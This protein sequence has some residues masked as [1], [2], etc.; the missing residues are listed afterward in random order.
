MNFRQIN[1]INDSISTTFGLLI[2]CILVWLIR[3]TR[4]DEMKKYNG[5]LLQIC[6][7]D[8]YLTIATF[9]VKPVSLFL[10]SP[11]RIRDSLVFNYLQPDNL[12]TFQIIL[13]DKGMEFFLMNGFFR[14]TTPFIGQILYQFWTFALIF[15]ITSVPV[16]TIFRY[17]ILCLN[18][19]F[20]TSHQF[21][22]LS[23]SAL[24]TVIFCIIIFCTYFCA[25]EEDLLMAETL[26]FLK[27][28]DGKVR[29][30]GLMKVVSCFILN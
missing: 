23:V 24:F 7:V 10:S 14:K 13:V 21:K 5:I 27:D 30:T 26:T 11:V 29:T 28:D 15:S 22:Y 1:E 4:I 8:I 19:P 3:T 12:W 9:I 17:K 18:Q 16:A 2:N 25:S 6:I 20:T